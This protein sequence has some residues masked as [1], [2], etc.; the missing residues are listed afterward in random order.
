MSRALVDGRSFDEVLRNAPRWLPEED[1]FLLSSF[2]QSGRLAEGLSLLAQKHAL[3]AQQVR[4]AWSA[5][6]YP[7]AV[8][9]FAIL[10]LPLRHIILGG[11]ETYLFKVGMFLLPLWAV[12]GVLTWAA[13]KR[14]RWL[15]LVTGVMPWLRGYR[16]NLAVADLAFSLES[17]LVAG[18]PVDLAWAGA[19]RA[20]GSHRLGRAARLVAEAARRGEPPGNLLPG[21]K[22]FPEEFVSLYQVGE[23]TGSLDQNLRHLAVLYR[24]RAAEKLKAASFW[25]PKFLFALIAIGVAYAVIS[26]YADYFRQIEDILHF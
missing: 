3:K 10:V 14:H 13:A 11:V 24:E 16:R 9:H 21:Q 20:S 17:F 19:G 25:Y 1:R 12:I 26:F 2:A 18:E 8:M 7:L 6:P 22:V 4:E 15:T 23:R 5:V